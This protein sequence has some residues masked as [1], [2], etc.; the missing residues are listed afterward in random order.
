[1]NTR[2]ASS[3]T[4]TPP[5]FGG[6]GDALCRHRPY[7]VRCASRRLRDPALAED[8]VQDTLL[9]ALQ[10]G[11]TFE[12]RA[13]LRTWL[14]GILKRQ[15]A[16]SL[17]RAAR[18]PLSI[19]DD[20]PGDEDYEAA[21]ADWLDPQRRLQGRQ[22]LEALA[23]GVAALP[24]RA[25]RLL[26]LRSIDGLGNAQAAARLGLNARQSAELLHRTRRELRAGL[27]PA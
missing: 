25:A 1:M 8:V 21:A 23:R 15:I 6:L 27:L 10:A 7:L 5:A 3:E 14:T 17:R 13:A 22:A 12:H 4:V 19:G 20:G 16:E 18:E 26:E 9:A 24:A 2:D 11:A